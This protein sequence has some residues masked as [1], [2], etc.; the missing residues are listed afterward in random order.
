MYMS[1]VGGPVGWTQHQSDHLHSLVTEY[2]PKWTAIAK[3]LNR[4]AYTCRAAYKRLL[5]RKS[6]S[7]L[8]IDTSIMPRKSDEKTSFENIRLEPSS[9]FWDTESDEILKSKVVKY[10]RKWSII[11]K[12]KTRD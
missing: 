2:G 6:T 9:S 11:G 7:S 4:T 3:Q 5:E 10:G 8:D 12:T 1:F